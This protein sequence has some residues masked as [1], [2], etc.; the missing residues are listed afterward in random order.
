[1]LLQNIMFW[2]ACLALLITIVAM[3]GILT[4]KGVDKDTGETPKAFLD[5]SAG[6]LEGREMQ[7]VLTKALSGARTDA[8]FEQ[9]FKAAIEAATGLEAETSWAW[10]GR[11]LMEYRRANEF[12]S[13]PRQLARRFLA[14]VPRRYNLKDIPSEPTTPAA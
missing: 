2:W 11:F 1:M 13:S 3:G 4:R 9:Q 10:L 7:N 12:E 5:F 8:E 14:D 6:Q